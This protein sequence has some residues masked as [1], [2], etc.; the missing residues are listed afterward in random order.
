MNINYNKLMIDNLNIF[1]SE[2]I[3]KGIDFVFIILEVVSHTYSLS[4][5]IW[6]CGAMSGH[7]CVL[8]EVNALI[9]LGQA[10]VAVSVQLRL[11]DPQLLLT[12]QRSQQALVLI[13]GV[14]LCVNPETVPELSLFFGQSLVQ[15]IV[16]VAE[17]V[18]NQLIVSYLGKY[19][20]KNIIRNRELLKNSWNLTIRFRRARSRSLLV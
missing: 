20:K 14:E 9:N 8:L 16:T 10:V 15:G 11:P 6:P 19:I 5:S 1:K 18:R 17:K 7:C 2:G 13:A 12:L 4:M 3:D